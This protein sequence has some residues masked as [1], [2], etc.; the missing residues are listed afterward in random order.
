MQTNV[1]DDTL[2]IGLD[3][4]TTTCKAAIY[5]SE[6]R[7]VGIAAEEYSLL[8]DD[9]GYIEQDPEEWWQV[10]CKTIRAALHKVA[11]T[12]G[13]VAEG[14][15]P[16]ATE[17]ADSTSFA[18]MTRRVRAISISTQSI[19][20]LPLDENMRPLA[21]AISWLDGRGAA[22][23]P[24]ITSH[25][26][27]ED[28]YR[29]TG[30]VLRGGVYVLTKLLW[31][32]TNEPQIWNRIRKIAFPLDYLNL[33]MCGRLATDHTIAGGTMFHNLAARDWDYE[34]LE[35]LEISADIL[36]ELQDSGTFVGEVSFAAAREMGL[37]HDPDTY[38]KH[39][40]SLMMGGQDQK[41]AAYGAGIRAESITLSMG[42][43]AASEML[44]DVDAPS[45]IDTPLFA[46]MESLPARFCW[47]FPG[48]QVMETSIGTA[49]A[50]LRWYRDACA[51]H[52]NYK[53]IDALALEVPIAPRTI[54]L[55]LLSMPSSETSACFT[56][57]TLNSNIGAMAR[58]VMEGVV[59]EMKLRLE[60]F[61]GQDKASTLRLFGGGGKSPLWSQIMADIL[62]K[63]IE[64]SE[65]SELALLGAAQLAAG[66]PYDWTGT[67]IKISTYS[68]DSDSARLYRQKYA[69]YKDLRNL[70]K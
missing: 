23:V 53:Q 51:S 60:T 64:V 19:S 3:L 17:S 31:W 47:L 55:P 28:I 69:Y 21:N 35:K 41:V 30:K 18:D 4:G 42:T 70:L 61:P 27:I 26:T 33:R 39:P 13:Y 59:F 34:I 67:G 63:T 11:T 43:S 45:I 56:G 25:F 1:H 62:E 5:D 24:T 36:P 49:G 65:D 29:R 15:S 54:F 57:L 8:T 58:A 50:A 14:A 12:L 48:K 52:L 7:C 9:H 68:P 10:S 32:R 6:L 22:E 37:A 40:V 16:I 44:I 2:Y 46:S 20:V 66:R 38:A